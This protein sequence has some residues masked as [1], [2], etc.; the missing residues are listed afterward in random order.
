MA[1]GRRPQA[2]LFSP[3]KFTHEAKDNG[4]S[5]LTEED[6]TSF[7][8]DSDRD[9][10]TMEIQISE[11]SGGIVAHSDRLGAYP[12]L[13]YVEPPTE[14]LLLLHGSYPDINQSRLVCE[15]LNRNNPM[16]FSEYVTNYSGNMQDLEEEM[17]K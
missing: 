17:L 13:A 2:Q 16:S 5:I 7:G 15:P 3:D 4:D 8:V 9:V 1:L 6:S 10:L 11:E 12:W 14:P